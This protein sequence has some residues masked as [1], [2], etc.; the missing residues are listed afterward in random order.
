V[1]QGQWDEYADKYHTYI[2][3]P[4][5]QN[6]NNPIFSDL[7]RLGSKRR[8]VA[9]LGCGIGDLL[10]YLAQRF[11]N[12]YAVDFSSKMLETAA[13]RNSEHENILF[14]QAD[15][16]ELTKFGL[17]LDVAVSVNS[18]LLPH[19][20]DINATLQQIHASLKEDGTFLGIFPSMESVLYNFMLVYEREYKKYGEEQKALEMTRRIIQGRKYNFITSVYADHP[21]ER[22]K[23]FYEFELRMRLRDAGFKNVEL[24]KVLYAWGKELSG[25]EDFEGKDEM[26][27]WYVTASK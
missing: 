8:I 13:G 24:K 14:V 4:F 23:F 11:K 25:Y 9:D 26:W 16:R 5:Q 22:Q 3:S 6:V 15:L 17:K 27:D 12:V 18:I 10:P 19:F 20:E 21:D 7:E 2:I 1:E